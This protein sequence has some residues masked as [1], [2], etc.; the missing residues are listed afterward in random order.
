MSPKLDNTSSLVDTGYGTDDDDDAQVHAQG[1]QD[2]SAVSNHPVSVPSAP[3]FVAAPPSV[4]AF[5][6]ALDPLHLWPT[7]STAYPE[8]R[9]TPPRDMFSSDF[10]RFLRSQGRDDLAAAIG[11]PTTSSFLYFRSL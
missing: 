8:Q 2:D 3:A 7:T 5:V 4:P 11:M 6:A 10:A 1:S 9:V